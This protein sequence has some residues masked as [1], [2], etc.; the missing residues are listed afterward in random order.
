MT[1]GGF[2]LNIRRIGTQARP[3]QK[4]AHAMFYAR[5]GDIVLVDSGTYHE[6]FRI[7]TGAAGRPVTLTA[8][9]GA[10]VIISPTIPITPQ[11]RQLGTSGVNRN[12][13]VADI[14]EYVKDMDTEFP[15]LFCK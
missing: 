8:M 5:P 3:F 7:P 9:P 11:W 12:I 15:Q 13:W 4:I 10:E 6:R 14:S 1:L 2:M